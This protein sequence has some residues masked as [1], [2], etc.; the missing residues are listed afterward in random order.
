MNAEQGSVLDYQKGE[1]G[2]ESTGAFFDFFFM[3]I[4]LSNL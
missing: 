1:I 2:L 4:T 3:P